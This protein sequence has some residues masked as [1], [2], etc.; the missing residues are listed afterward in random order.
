MGEDME[1]VDEV[2]GTPGGGVLVVDDDADLRIALGDAIEGL[3]DKKWIGAASLDDLAALG[4]RALACELAI[5]DINLGPNRPSGLD[6]FEWLQ[7][8]NY[9]G[10][11]AFLTGHARSNPLVERARREHRA[12][13]YEKPLSVEQ[14]GA[15]VEVCP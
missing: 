4:D 1:R 11:V 8:R 15:L 10:R 7:G 6:A 14:L 5:I 3:F 9:K 13:V 12:G 2:R